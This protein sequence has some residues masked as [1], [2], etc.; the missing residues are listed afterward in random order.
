MKEEYT[1]DQLESVAP[2]STIQNYYD[3]QV[4]GNKYLLKRLFANNDLGAM[5][6]EHKLRDLNKNE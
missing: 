5:V 1:L 6:I 4:K 3:V 2:L